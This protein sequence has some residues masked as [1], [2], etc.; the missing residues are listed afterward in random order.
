MNKR[1]GTLEIINYKVDNS[2]YINYYHEKLN[3]ILNKYEIKRKYIYNTEMEL[4]FN[5][6]TDSKN[7]SLEIRS[8]Y[9]KVNRNQYESYL[10]INFAYSY[11]L[12][13]DKHISITVNNYLILKDE[14]YY[15]SIYMDNNFHKIIEG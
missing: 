6:K 2:E 11:C 3:Q 1:G 9:E 4:I 12:C 8:L 14:K 13:L 5:N 15:S 10:Y 7:A